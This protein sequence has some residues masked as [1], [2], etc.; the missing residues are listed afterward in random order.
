MYF[1]EFREGLRLL[2]EAQP[3]LKIGLG[4]CH[5]IINELYLISCMANEDIEICLERRLAA[6]KKRTTEVMNR[7]EIAECRME[8]KNK[9]SQLLS[10][11]A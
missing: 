4:P 1:K 5:P 3:L 7:N 8:I 10:P 2:D 11:G 9:L 6:S